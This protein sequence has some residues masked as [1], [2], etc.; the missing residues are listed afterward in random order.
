M[1]SHSA[2]VQH[3]P[4][5]DVLPRVGPID[6]VHLARQCLGDE[7]LEQEV[8]RLFDTTMKTYLARLQR[9][10]GPNE[11]RLTLHSTKGAAMGVGAWTIADLALAAEQELGES[12][13]V[14]AERLADIGMAIEE[15]SRFIADILTDEAP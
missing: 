2:S 6:R 4:S 5:K 1:A 10:A 9:D 3:Q 12:V 15:V 14:G 13:V 11:I 7:G 8:L